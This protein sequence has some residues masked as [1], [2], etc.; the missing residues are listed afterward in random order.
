M[1]EKITAFIHS[2]S[3]YDYILFGSA[4]FLFLLSIILAVALRNRLKT[5][6]F[7][8]LF[9]FMSLLLGPT[10]GYVQLHKYLYKNSVELL[11]SKQLHFTSA[12]VIKGMLHNQSNFDFHTCKI[13][14]KISRK[15]PNKYK[16]Y[17]YQFKPF[18]KMSIVVE[19]VGKGE[20]RPFKMLLEPFSYK[21]EYTISLGADCL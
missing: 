12:L 2:L 19:G 5:A 17:I 15:T 14:A 21:K 13:T 8:L 18:A 1:K 10:F 20:S 16:N 9:G 7:F 6:L 11:E 3:M 4:F